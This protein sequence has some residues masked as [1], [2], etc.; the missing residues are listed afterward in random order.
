MLVGDAARHERRNG[1]VSSPGVN[2]G[3]Q[4]VWGLRNIE[5]PPP[6]SYVPTGEADT[7]PL[8][9]PLPV[10]AAP[11]PP[12][13]VR[14]AAPNGTAHKSDDLEASPRELHNHVQALVLVGRP[15]RTKCSHDH[16]GVRA[17]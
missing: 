16:A 11:T 7:E 13:S 14:T 5:D 12:E 2:R 15:A 10:L 6:G 8:H 3:N 9:Y 4:E 17:G 1:D